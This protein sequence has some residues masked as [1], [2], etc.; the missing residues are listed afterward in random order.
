MRKTFLLLQGPA[1]PFFAHLAARLR[2]EGHRVFKLNF[3]GG[4][5]LYGPRSDNLNYRGTVFDLR[6]FLDGVYRRCC[7]TDQVLFGDR[8]PVHRPAIEHGKVLGVRTHVYE[9]G[10]FRPHWVTLEEQG[11]NARS[12]LPRDAD[13]YWKVGGCLQDPPD[14][15]GI[16]SSFSI[17]AMHDVRYHLAGLANLILFSHYQTH[18]PVATAVE[19]AGYM[20]RLP[21][22][23]LWYKRR[24]AGRI[25]AW[26]SENQPFFVLPMQLDSDAQIRD[27]SRFT[28]MCEVIEYVVQSF[29]QHAASDTCLV[30]KNHPLSPGLVNYDRFI[31]RVAARSGVE[32]RVRY[33]EGG[34]LELLMRHARGCVTVNSTAGIVALSFGCPTMA[35]SDPVY[36]L[37]GLTFQGELDGF[38]R[39]A[40]L[41]DME[42]FRRFRRVVIRAAQVEGGFYCRAGIAMAVENSLSV[43]TSE[44]S[45]LEV[46]L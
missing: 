29:A 42:L 24:D 9:E 14:P 23:R 10:Y 1:T 27:H 35:L 45:P 16:R 7:I 6:D 21:M 26:I 37:R 4:D 40:E 30:I 36:K 25:A 18:A 28:D 43:L 22:M 13:W 31:R 38:W 34:D 39:D 33:L 3:N 19:Y 11:V 20:K 2:S 46:L 8:R 15:S 32:G 17:R 5:W 41:P 44:R 12:M